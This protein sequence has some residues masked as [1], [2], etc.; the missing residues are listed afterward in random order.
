MNR[1]KI[2]AIAAAAAALAASCVR[3]ESSGLNDANKRYFDAW[4]QIHHPDAVREGLGVYILDETVGSGASVGKS[5]DYPYLY[6]T[7]TSRDLDG[8]I[9]ETTDA[10]VARQVGSYTDR[11][12]YGPTVKM[13]L[14]TAMTAGQEMVIA[15]MRVGGSRTAAI[16]GWF[17]TAY[18]YDK[19][20]DYLNRITGEDCIYTVTIKDVIKD[21]SAWQIDSVTRYITRN[22]GHPVDSL[23]YGFYYIRTQ[24]PT[25][26]ASFEPGTAVSVNYTGRLL[27]GKVFDTTDEKTA[28]DAG[29]YSASSEYSPLTVNMAEEYESITTST[30][31]GEGSLVKGFSFCVSRMR[32][33]EKGTCIFISD[34]GYEANAQ[35]GIPAYSPLLFEVEMVGKKK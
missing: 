21:I 23:K 31:S 30:S 22:Y 20:Q 15:P 6:I 11:N 9:T 2:L 5:E 32:T 7:Y 33:G 14:A 12:Y 16:P 35:G 29:M 25:D 4:M 19:E 17:S 13:R 3:S 10:A 1:F 8:N 34:L 26:T 28:K 18:R 24:E 27:N